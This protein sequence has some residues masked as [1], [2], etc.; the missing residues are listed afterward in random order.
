MAYWWTAIASRQETAPGP[1]A[2]FQL[3]MGK[4]GMIWAHTL[5]PR[6]PTTVTM[7]TH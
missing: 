6:R 3:P 2:V 5:D 7:A 1:V 4:P